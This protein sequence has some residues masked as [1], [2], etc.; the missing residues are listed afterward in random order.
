ML[1]KVCLMLEKKQLN[2]LYLLIRQILFSLNYES[3]KYQT[4]K[5]FILW[6][7]AKNIVTNLRRI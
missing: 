1:Q 3:L 2:V 5:K 6:Q 4:H 7:S